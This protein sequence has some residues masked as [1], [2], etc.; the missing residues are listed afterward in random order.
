MGFGLWPGRLLLASARGESAFR[1]Q[2]KPQSA[3]DGDSFYQTNVDD[4]PQPVHDTA[5][6]ADQRMT[7]LVIV[8]IFASERA[9]RDQAIGA[10]IGK[11]DKKPGTGNA[12]DAA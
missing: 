10:G 2:F 1:Q 4:V 12:G 7:R 11:F 9:D 5:A 3:G 8:E 6:R